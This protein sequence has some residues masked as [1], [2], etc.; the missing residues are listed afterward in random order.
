MIFWCFRSRCEGF[1][2]YL[3]IDLD[4]VQ[5]DD[6]GYLHDKMRTG[7]ADLPSVYFRENRSNISITVLQTPEER[8]DRRTR[9]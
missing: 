5:M 1:E 9:V 2:D 6:N 7:S 3:I 8:G 4:V